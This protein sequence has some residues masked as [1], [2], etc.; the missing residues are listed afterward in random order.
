MQKDLLIEI[1]KSKRAAD[2]AIKAAIKHHWNP[3]AL[4][5]T[6]LT[7]SLAGLTIALITILH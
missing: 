3:N 4:E 1:Q 5:L 2:K 6:A 7:C